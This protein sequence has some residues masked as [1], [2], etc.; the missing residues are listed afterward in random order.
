MT[1]L[2]LGIDVGGT[3]TRWAL[4]EVH[5]RSLASGTAEA[6]PGF[7]LLPE[8]RAQCESVLQAI[9]RS[10]PELG[11]PSCVLAGIS[12]LDEQTERHTATRQILSH[13]LG[14]LSPDAIFCT[15]MHSLLCWRQMLSFK[16]NAEIMNTPFALPESWTLSNF[17]EVWKSGNFGVYFR[18]SFIVV[19]GAETL[20]LALSAMAGFALGRYRFRLNGVIYTIFFMGLM[21]PAKLL[22][23]PLFIQLKAMG[24]LDSL[25]SLTLV[26]AA[27]GIPAGVFILTGFF[28]LL[29]TA[30]DSAARIDGA[31]D[32]T[33]FSQILLPLLRPQLV[34]VANFTA[35]PIWN[36]FLLPIVFISDPDKKTVPQGLSVFFGEHAVNMGALIAG[37]SLAALPLIILYIILSEEFI[38]GLTAGAV[39]G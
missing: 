8:H 6:F 4:T 30:L 19:V 18:N 34:I 24:L 29:P 5:G 25:T 23:V 36:D 11:T 33:I 38:K 15:T 2:R 28:R 32:W 9:G 20:I 31:N 12:G 27:G 10:V 37:F 39:K 17:E 16:S 14:G 3:A 7:W 35:I 26:Y 1:Q 21:I 22:L 13:A